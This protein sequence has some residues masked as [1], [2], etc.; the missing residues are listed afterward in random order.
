MVKTEVMEFG[1]NSYFRG[2]QGLTKVSEI[3]G[4]RAKN[5]NRV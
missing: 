3:E 2:L 5:K 1:E 4:L